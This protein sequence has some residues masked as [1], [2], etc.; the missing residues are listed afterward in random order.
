MSRNPIVIRV[1]GGDLVR[2][3]EG[4]RDDL[5]ARG[6][7]ME[8]IFLRQLAQMAATPAGELLARLELP[9]RAAPRDQRRS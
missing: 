3:L 9:E 8:D 4:L 5:S 7:D 6:Y 2:Q 1:G